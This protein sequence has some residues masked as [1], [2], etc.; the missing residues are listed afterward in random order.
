MTFSGRGRHGRASLHSANGFTLVELTVVIV[1]IGIL[2]AIILPAFLGQ[3]L[4]AQ[5]AETK[6][7]ASR[8][9][10]ALELH[11][12]EHD[13]YAA[14]RNDVLAEAPE[15]DDAR[16]WSLTASASAYT[17]SVT[18]DNQ[19]VFTIRRE[20]GRPAERTCTAGPDAAGSGGCKA[21]GRW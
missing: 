19:H 16:D 6:A 7:L 13:S 12:N 8:G 17:L 14:T 2:A 20:R 9:A 11:A 5:D 3:R 4:K 18:G 10:L 1:V 15:L 21:D